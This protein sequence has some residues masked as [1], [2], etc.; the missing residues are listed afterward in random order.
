MGTARVSDHGFWVLLPKDLETPEATKQPECMVIA[1]LEPLCLCLCLS[2]VPWGSVDT[3]VSCSKK[4]PSRKYTDTVES[5]LA[6][7]A[8]EQGER[9][10]LGGIWVLRMGFIAG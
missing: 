10:L 9:R 5:K 2:C 3:Y 8:A 1:Q 7:A 6:S 4:I